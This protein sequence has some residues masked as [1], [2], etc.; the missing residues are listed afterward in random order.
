MSTSDEHAV[1]ARAEARQADP[2]VQSRREAAHRWLHSSPDLEHGPGERSYQ[3]P[4]DMT[5]EDR[6]EWQRR[7]DEI[8][9]EIDAAPRER[10]ADFTDPHRWGKAEL[11][12][13]GIA[14][15]AASQRRALGIDEAGGRTPQPVDVATRRP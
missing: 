9:A 15:Y 7:A 10:P 14:E 4:D 3:H 5:P 8:A 13:G 11:G 2:R 1:L 6:E 12:V